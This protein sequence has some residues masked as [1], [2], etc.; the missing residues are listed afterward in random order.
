MHGQVREL[1]SN[2][3]RQVF[4]DLVDGAGGLSVGLGWRA[5]VPNDPSTAANILIN[6]GWRLARRF[7]THPNSALAA[8]GRAALGDL[9]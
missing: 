8:T 7:R 6:D 5:A 9:Q 3:G 1:L 2:Y 4:S